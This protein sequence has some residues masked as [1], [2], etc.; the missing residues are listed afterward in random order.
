MKKILTLILL[1]CA[2]ITAKSLYLN[3]NIY[4][5]FDLYK[6]NFTPQSG[7]YV[8]EADGKN[9]I[10]L[11]KNINLQIESKG[12][13]IVIFK[14][15]IFVQKVKQLRIYGQG[16][17]NNFSLSSDKKGV[18]KRDYDDHVWLTS[19]KG[20]LDIVNRVELEHYVAGVVQAEGGGSSKN[21][22]YFMVQAITCRTY[23][24]VN[25]MKHKAQGF[26]LC[27][28]VHC[29]LYLGKCKNP[30]IARAVARTSGDVI[31]D[32][33]KRMISAAFHSNCGGQTV[34]SED[35]WSIP[36]SYLKSITDTFCHT[37][38]NAH[39]TKHYS[40]N[41]WLS[42]LEQKYNYPIHDTAMRRQA[43]EFT[44]IER[45]KFFPNN[46]LLKDMRRDLYLRSTFFSIENRGDTIVLKGN[47]Y[48]HGVGLCQQ[49]A[50]VMA[51]K[52]YTYKEIIYYYYTNSLI[53]NYQ[54]LGY[55]FLKD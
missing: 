16:F 24:L 53:I 40:K 2:T 6:I 3:I 12:D 1:V 46:I 22:E 14:E 41:D 7:L 39:W 51:D 33:D 20:Y 48:G 52:G 11:Y 37:G 43:L 31:V 8:V 55:V 15:G 36:T 5:E 17:I 30:E 26:N 49:G 44:Q 21:L 47:G 34:N 29:Q 4:S 54:E 23:A 45:Q 27:D 32:Q 38:R 18:P 28:A 50:I 13:S 9:I 25:Y 35:I 42:I 19:R 10:D